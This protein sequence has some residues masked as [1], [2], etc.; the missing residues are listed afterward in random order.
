MALTHRLEFNSTGTDYASI[1]LGASIF[2]AGTGQGRSI[3]VIT[4]LGDR[5]FQNTPTGVVVAECNEDQEGFQVDCNAEPGVLR[6][7][8]VSDG[9]ATI[10]PLRFAIPAGDAPIT[11]TFLNN[12]SNNWTIRAAVHKWIVA[13]DTSTYSGGLASG[14]TAITLGVRSGPADHLDVCSFV[15]AEGWTSALSDGEIETVF[16]DGRPQDTAGPARWFDVRMG[17]GVG[18]TST[19]AVDQTGN[20]HDLT[21]VGTW[22]TGGFTQWDPPNRVGLLFD[23]QYSGNT[24]GWDDFGNAT[25]DAGPNGVRITT[26]STDIRACARYVAFPML[27]ANWMARVRIKVTTGGAGVFGFGSTPDRMSPSPGG[28]AAGLLNATEGVGVSTNLTGEFT[29]D[30]GDAEVARSSDPAGTGTTPISDGSD[31]LVD[32]SPD[33]G[34]VYVGIVQFTGNRFTTTWFNETDGG[35]P[36]TLVSDCDHT[37]G[38]SDLRHTTPSPGYLSVLNISSA[39]TIEVLSLECYSQTVEN[40]YCAWFTHSLANVGETEWAQGYIMAL[41]TL[42]EADGVFEWVEPFGRPGATIDEFRLFDAITGEAENIGAQFVAMCAAANTIGQEDRTEAEADTIDLVDHMRDNWAVP[43]SHIRLVC[44]PPMTLGGETTLDWRGNLTAIAAGYGSG[45]STSFAMHEGMGDPEGS[46]NQVAT[47]FVG[48][49]DNVH[50][51]PAGHVRAAGFNHTGGAAVFPNSVTGTGATTAAAQVASAT[52]LVL[53]QGGGAS[54]APAQTVAASGLVLVRGSGASQ[55]PA[56]SA[57]ATG[58]VV[59]AGTAA[60][61]AAPQ[62]AS[63]TGNVVVLGTGAT[64]AAAQVTSGSSEGAITGTGATVAAAQST[65]ALGAVI[66]QGIGA[67]AAAAQLAT[68]LGGPVVQGVASSTSAAQVASGTGVSLVAGTG[69]T[70]AAAQVASATGDVIVTGTGATVAAAQ[71]TSGTTQPVSTG[72]GATSAAPQVTAG[73][74]E[75]YEFSSRSVRTKSATYRSYITSTTRAA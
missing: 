7:I 15:R 46:N 50:L 20:S 75:V 37:V 44:E 28:A 11:L 5:S 68:A 23:W 47:D 55:S 40:P 1:A 71:V 60:T 41:N 9:G 45:V 66:V 69:A 42:R 53:I 70:V 64:I 57:S 10:R 67:S 26:S 72:E 59:V 4:R 36:L 48:G 27:A 19:T 22:A 62:A 25:I 35:P 61:Q 2:G 29:A 73:Q 38:A 56:Q 30:W 18:D 24:T 49:G 65:A 58:A 16:A 12:G 52:G 74:G 32:P 63:A 13:S 51:S 31:V 54:T 34:D 3:R 6:L 8:V 43:P 21:L 39:T 14:E 17:S 33:D